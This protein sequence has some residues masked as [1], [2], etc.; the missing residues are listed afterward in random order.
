MLAS[1]LGMISGLVLSGA[2]TN[3]LAEA[4]FLSNIRQLTYEG[5][6]SGEGY[7]SPDGKAL[8][9]QSER[10][11]GNPFYQI[12]ILDLESGESHR[13]SPGIGKTTCGSSGP[14]VTRCYSPP[15][16]MI[17]TRGPNRRQ[18]W[19]FEPPGSS[20]VTRGITMITWTFGRRGGMAAG[21]GGSPI[22]QDD[23][24][25]SYSPDGKIAFCSLRDAYPTNKLSAAEQKHMES[26][27]AYFGEIYI[28]NAGRLWTTEAH[29]HTRLRWR[30]LFSPDGNR[31]IWRR[32]DE[33]GMM[34]DIYTMKLTAPMC[35]G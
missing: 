35:A 30:A 15:L 33:S 1:W 14:A 28:M 27:P 4:R 34:A 10:E 26:D 31:I 13:V 21:C 25:A 18:S 8:I 3:Q 22:R 2:E 12:Y 7:S 17:P 32:F 20:A 24:E 29:T 16:T 11:A 5:R 9:F 23:A 6:R 19:I